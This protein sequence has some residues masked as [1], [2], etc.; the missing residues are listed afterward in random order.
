MIWAENIEYMVELWTE[1][2]IYWFSATWHVRTSEFNVL[3]FGLLKRRLPSTS[4][5]SLMAKNHPDLL[6]NLTFIFTVVLMACLFG[7]GLN[8]M[9]SRNSPSNEF[10]RRIRSFMDHLPLV[11]LAWQF[12]ANIATK[13]NN[14]AWKAKE[15]RLVC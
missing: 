6:C 15:K 3:P 10:G 2:F 4:P 5:L 12:D 9:A 13:I 14:N 1:L 8:A 7:L 11:G